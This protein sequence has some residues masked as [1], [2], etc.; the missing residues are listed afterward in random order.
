[1]YML[2]AGKNSFMWFGPTPRLL[3][4]DP[5]LIKEVLTTIYKFKKEKQNPIARMFSNGLGIIEG[6]R[7]AQHRK[8]LNPAFHLHKLKVLDYITC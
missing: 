5:E 7:W 4:T 6:D 8:L 2:L 3:I 1:M